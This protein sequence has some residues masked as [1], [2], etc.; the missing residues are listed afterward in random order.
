MLLALLIAATVGLSVSTS[1]RDKLRISDAVAN[2]EQIAQGNYMTSLGARVAMWKTAWLIFEDHPLIGIG[3]GRFQAEIIRRIEMGE[4]PTTEIYNQPHSDIMHALSSGG[5]LKFFAYLGI[6][7]APLV[8]FYKRFREEK[9]N[10]DRWLM[11]VLGM[12]V[13]GAYFLTGLTNSNF[14]LQIYSTTYAVLVCVLANLSSL[15]C[16]EVS[17]VNK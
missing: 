4:I 17:S 12:Q 6:L 7:F 3:P 11:S 13:V 2:V 15:E 14:D 16:A 8:F 1:L 5:L 10:S 9:N